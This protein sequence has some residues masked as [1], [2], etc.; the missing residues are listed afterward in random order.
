M[1][2]EKPWQEPFASLLNQLSANFKG[3]ISSQKSRPEA[4]P[5]DTEISFFLYPSFR[6]EL[7]EQK[8][9]IEISEFPE[10]AFSVFEAEDNVEYLRIFAIQPSQYSLVITHEN[11]LHQFKKKLHLESEF[12]SGSE[13]FDRRYYLR[14]E[15]DQDQRFLKKAKFQNVVK[16]L[17]PFSVLE[18]LKSGILWSQHIADEKQ[19]VY[20][21]VA[22]YLRKILEL[23][24]I[25]ADR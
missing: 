5:I 23:V 18:I 2:W 9:I 4:R 3:D 22:R 12:Q 17:E 25:I 13:E 21:K 6:G 19:L 7:H 10:F 14:P 16:A 15:S 11:W 8:F 20:S 24:E 1:S